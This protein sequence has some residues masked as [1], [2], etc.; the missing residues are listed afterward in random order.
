MCELYRHFDAEGNLLYVGISLF[1]VG[2]LAQ[3]KVHAGW[4][5]HISFITVHRYKSREA[6]RRAEKL[7]IRLEKPLWNQKP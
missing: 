5:S 1:A 7:F 3:H 6:A 2:R 4:S